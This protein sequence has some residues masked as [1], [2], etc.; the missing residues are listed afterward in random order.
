MIID[1]LFKPVHVTFWLVP[2][3][4]DNMY[5]FMNVSKTIK[6]CLNTHLHTSSSERAGNTDTLNYHS[7]FIAIS[8]YH[9]CDISIFAIKNV[10]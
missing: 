5:K 2:K 3:A 8:D 9:V 6:A 4:S 7:L 10:Q 1:I